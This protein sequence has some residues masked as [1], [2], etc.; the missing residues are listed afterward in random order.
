GGNLSIIYSV[1]GSPDQVNG[2]G[3]ILFIEDV[4]EMLYHVDRMMMNL[5][6]ANVLAG[7]KA[8]VLGGMTQMKD[9]TKAFGFPDDNPFGSSAVQIV[10]R[11]AEE[12]ELPVFTGFPAGHQS[13]NCAFYLGREAELSISGQEALLQYI[14]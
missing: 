3:S 13:N 12:L 14:P 9:N 2:K 11:I 8:I 4:D 1:L 10:C 6:R 5:K 7:V